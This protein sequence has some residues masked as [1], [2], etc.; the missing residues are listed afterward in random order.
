[1][2]NWLGR[3]NLEVLTFIAGTFIVCVA[4]FCPALSV[5]QRFIVGFLWLFTLHEWEEGRYPGGF[6]DLIGDNLLKIEVSGELAGL[7]R[8]PTMCLIL[9]FTVVPFFFDTVWW[10]VMLPVCLGIMEGIVHMACIRLFRLKRFYS[11]GMA[12]AL[13]ELVV[14][15]CCLAYLIACCA[16]PWWDYL[17]SVALFFGCFALMQSRLVKLIGMRYRDFPKFMRGRMLALIKGTEQ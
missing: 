15:G 4:A 13:V 5:V 9:G 17:I 11:P 7:S 14:G 10:L 16:V 12:T 1:M 6:L 2:R 3:Y 8:I